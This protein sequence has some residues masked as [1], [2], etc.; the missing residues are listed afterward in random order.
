MLQFFE[1]T[2]G[3]RVAALCVLLLVKDTGMKMENLLISERLMV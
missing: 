3:L 2:L 1:Y